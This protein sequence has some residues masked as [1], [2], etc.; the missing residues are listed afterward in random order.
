M[1]P[2]ALIIDD[3]IQIR[4]LLRLVLEAE[5][6]KVH[7][8]ET[9]QQGLMEIATRKPDVVL[10]D[11]GLPD[12]EG[13][14]V[15]KRLREWSE[16]PVIVLT[17]RDDVQ[18]KVAALDAGAD[19]YITKPFST[20]ELLARLRAAQRKT[21]PSEE[22]SV[23]KNG[24]LVVDLTAHVVTRAGRE[25]KLSATEYALL[26]LFVKHPG[27]VLTHRHILREIWGPK[28][29][30]HRQYLRV[31]VTHLRQKIERDPTKPSL[32]QTQS[33]IGSLTGITRESA[34]QRA[35]AQSRVTADTDGAAIRR[36]CSRRECGRAST[37]QFGLETRCRIALWRLGDQQ[38]VCDRPR[39]SRRWIL[40][41]TDHSRSLR[42]DSARGHQLHCHLSSLPR[43]RRRILIRA[44]TG[45]FASRGGG[46]AARSRSD[47]NG[48]SQRLVGTELRHFRR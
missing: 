31:Y 5:N 33:G 24:D 9:G 11:L 39:V 48:R 8:A 18:E 27:R 7:E 10:L 3:E 36:C 43:W 4:R 13:L 32:I 44:F 40:I 12:V 16:V 29:E 35:N 15:L 19:D 22:V 21:R 14:Q 1:N 2:V 45:T 42:S 47:G 41:S 30:E 38:G 34:C 28:S 17:V 26:R 20:P 25:I 23:F 6:Y 46:P 37:A